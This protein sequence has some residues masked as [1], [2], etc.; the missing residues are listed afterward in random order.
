MDLR[1]RLNLLQTHPLRGAASFPEMH[2]TGLGSD[3]ASSPFIDGCCPGRIG[4][5][6]I[7]IVELTHFP[8][9]TAAKY[10]IRVLS[11]MLGC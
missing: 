6:S 8:V 4:F 3:R 10:S 1:T 5:P 7:S 2:S 11:R 9:E